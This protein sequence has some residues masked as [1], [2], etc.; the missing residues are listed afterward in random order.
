MNGVAEIESVRVPPISELAES[1]L[2]GRCCVWCGC[3]LTVGRIVDLGERAEGG[4]R[5]FPRAC[6][7]CT[8]KQVYLQLIEHAGSCE[9]CV[10]DGALCRSSIELRRALR[11][12][13]AR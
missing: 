6:R 10:D 12:G 9:Q 1:Q 11:E 2:C 4:R 13:R 3:A 8:A 7:I 5:L